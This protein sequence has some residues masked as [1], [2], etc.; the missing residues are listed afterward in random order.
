ML[1]AALPPYARKP[2]APKVFGI[3]I[4]L[5]V[6]AVL[7][8]SLIATVFDILLADSPIATTSVIATID[9]YIDFVFLIFVINIDIISRNI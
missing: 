5:A 4:V 1:I 9:T 3:V 6:F 8:A 2:S 7:D